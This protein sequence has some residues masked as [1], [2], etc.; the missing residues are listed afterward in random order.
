MSK[1]NRNKGCG[2]ANIPISVILLF[3]GGGFW[4]VKKYGLPEIDVSQINSALAKIPG[5]EIQIPVKE[6]LTPTVH[7]RQHQHCPQRRSHLLP[8]RQHL[9][10]I[11]LNRML[12]QK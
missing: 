9:I 4:A 8:L 5:I 10:Q 3:L 11:G 6:P 12:H 1:A 2:C 7:Q